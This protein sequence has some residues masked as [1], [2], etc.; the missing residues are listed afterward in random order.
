MKTLRSYSLKQ[1]KDWGAALA[2]RLLKGGPA[3]RATVLALYGELGSGKT[4]FVQGFFA[5][6]GAG[7]TA[8]P[9]FVLMRRKGL[10]GK[11]F[12]SLFHIDAYRIKQPRELLKIG[13]G[14]ILVDPGAIVL[15]EWAD[16][17]GRLVGRGAWRIKFAHG[18]KEN[19][20]IIKIK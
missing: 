17:A 12:H 1:T 14:E 6:L 20:R 19:E 10:S 16:R 11:A 2:R 7:R 13:L 9:T 5:G 18:R 8:S 3:R 4:S 15:I